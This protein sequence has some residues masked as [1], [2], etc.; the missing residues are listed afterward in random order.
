MAVPNTT[1]IVTLDFLG[2]KQEVTKGPFARMFAM[3]VPAK[4]VEEANRQTD[5]A[6]RSGIIN[7]LRPPADRFNLTFIV[8]VVSLIA[9]LIGAVVIVKS[10]LIKFPKLRVANS[11][12]V[13]TMF[14]FFSMNFNPRNVDILA[15]RSYARIVLAYLSNIILF[16]IVIYLVAT[17]V[18]LLRQKMF[19]KK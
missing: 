6:I 7:N 11:L 8:G 13:S 12:I 3:T 2:F 9:V 16:F 14:V 5:V 10:S 1:R 15:T 17:V 19:N 18:S 4:Y